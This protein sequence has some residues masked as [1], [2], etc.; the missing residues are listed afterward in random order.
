MRFVPGQLGQPVWVDDPHFNLAYHVRHSALPPPGREAE[1]NNLMARLMAVE[2]DRHRPLW[3]VWMIEGLEDGRWALISKLHHCMVDGVSGTDLIVQLLDDSRRPAAPPVDDWAPA[4]E[5]SD[6]R[7]AVDGVFDSLRF[8][9]RQL[10]SATDLAR[11]P[12]E[13]FAA[14]RAIASGVKTLG[15]ELQPVPMLSIEGAIGPHRRWAAAR[16]T[17]TN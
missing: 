4:P 2:L 3:E 7:L 16:A 5:P 11:R 1:L 15:R 12:R 6:A 13:S 9:A 17:S 10:Q 8:P 14:L